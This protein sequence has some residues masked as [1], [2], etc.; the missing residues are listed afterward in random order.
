M[1]IQHESIPDGKRH[2]PKGISSASDKTVYK[3]NGAASGVWDRIRD[4]DLDYTD[5]TK[6][7][8]GW[9][10][11][12]DNL[13][14]SGAPKAIAS[15][16]RTQ[17]T[18]NGLASQSDTSRLGP[19]WNTSTN[20][21]LINDLNAFY[22]IRI[23]F[24]ATAAAAAGTP[25]VITVEAETANGPTTIIGSTHMI[26]GGGYVNHITFQRSLY[27]GIFINNYGL[28]IFVT[29]DTNINLYDIGFVIHREYKET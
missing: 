3:A 8:F 11:I 22:S 9:N 20:Q 7:L 18:N 27:S 4:T 21:F 13:Y 14:T 10:D 17:L 25:Y 24:K 6:N 19:V 23:S 12:A 28:K 29:P 16:I 5:K 26:K 1:P 2:E 15:G